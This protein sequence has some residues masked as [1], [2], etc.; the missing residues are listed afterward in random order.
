M[1]GI[2]ST[3]MRESGFDYKIN[4]GIELPRLEMIATEVRENI[5]AD[6]N[7]ET[8]RRLSLELWS[9][10]IR[11]SKILAMMLMPKSEFTR[12]FAELW[13]GGITN[14]EL[15]RLYVMYLLQ[16][17]SF[18]TDIAFR[19]TAAADDWHQIC[20]LL[21]MKRLMMNGL[22]LQERAEAELR[23]QIASAQYSSNV[24]LAQLAKSMLLMQRNDAQDRNTPQREHE[25]KH[26]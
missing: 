22:E 6:S 19:W 20:G 3:R 14:I 1:N 10:Q 7:D 5:I 13:S 17:A 26:C 15:A 16:H 9:E 11:E 23:D 4:F 8:L 2:A 18:A 21:L 24:F 25:E 12:D